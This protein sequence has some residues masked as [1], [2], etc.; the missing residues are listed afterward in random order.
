[1][2]IAHIS[3]IHIRLASRHEEYRK[4]F[5]SLFLS[6]K[7]KAVDVI[8]IA[9]DTLHSKSEMSPESIIL[10]DYFFENLGKIAPTYV[11]LGNHDCSIKN[12]S[13]MDVLSPVFEVKKSYTNVELLTSV[14]RKE[15]G[16]DVDAYFMDILEPENI[17]EI[18]DKNKCNIAIAHGMMKGSKSDS[19]FTF[20]SGELKK[21]DFLD[22]DIVMLGDI[23]RRQDIIPNKIA[24]SGSLIQQN[25]GESED[26]G[27]LIWDTKFKSYEFVRVQNDHVF[28]TVRIKGK[29][30]P[31]MGDIPKHLNLR[32]LWEMDSTDIVDSEF[33]DIHEK[34]RSTYSPESLTVISI[35]PEQKDD[36]FH[37]LNH[38]ANI[39]QFIDQALTQAGAESKLTKDQMS[40]L[41]KLD[42]EIT[43]KTN[44]PSLKPISWT[45]HKQKF[46]NIFSYGKN[47][48][49]DWNNRGVTG[50]FAPNAMGKSALV[51]SFLFSLYGKVSRTNNL[52]DVIQKGKRSCKSEIYLEAERK[53]Y[54]IRRKA[55]LIKARLKITSGPYV[56][57]ST[58]EV[59][60]EVKEGSKWTKLNGKDKKDTDKIIDRYFGSF[61]DFL[62]TSF[63]AQGDIERFIQAPAP[64]RKDILIRF[65]G[66]DF[67][68]DKYAL[69]K[70]RA[71]SMDFDIK[72]LSQYIAG[73][74][75]EDIKSTIGQLKID[76]QKY[77]KKIKTTRLKDIKGV[78]DKLEIIQEKK[79][80]LKIGTMELKHVESE[81]KLLE[82]KTKPLRLASL[83]KT[84]CRTCLLL[85]GAIESKKLLVEKR[86]AREGLE[87]KLLGGIEEEIK[88][89]DEKELIRQKEEYLDISERWRNKLAEINAKR[90]TLADSLLLLEQKKDELKSM[91]EKRKILDVYAKAIH[92]DGIPYQIIL[93]Y[94]PI[95]NIEI[96]NILSGIVDF[97]V[98]ITPDT[99]DRRA[100]QVYIAHKNG[101]ERLIDVASGMEK[102][103]T[104]L[105]LRA[106]MTKISKL[107]KPT[108][109]VIDEGFGSLDKDNLQSM[110]LLF[111][112]L[113]TM[114]TNILIIS[115]VPDLKDIVDSEIQITKNQSESHISN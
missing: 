66:L 85:A 26:K 14:S 25:F 111:Q 6:L 41:V 62:L 88:S 89:Y 63:S 18:Q 104:S 16:S 13:K 23:H 69:A 22:F 80:L 79:N 29:D 21:E 96:N 101:D 33:L 50:I 10:T 109:W 70:A 78:E 108:I 91:E 64:D 82:K 93:K 54:R 49:I 30:L 60:F 44:I 67:M 11:I 71:K 100:L 114:F 1:L 90:G 7:E 34:I 48:S 52:R 51:D 24:Y 20:S 94:L 3:D 55:R 103:I 73:I 87:E 37:P 83:D 76:S 8:V 74:N 53:T 86:K 81:I 45:P 4:V 77:G 15:L 59:D 46:S 95:L 43:Q 19:G 36:N 110:R 56:T 39:H 47:N 113:K 35:P 61:E 115:H 9:G 107:P 27:Y 32:V 5:S 68:E 31:P 72:V 102:M 92:R 57:R 99:T 28:R 38:D 2:K 40:S 42:Q 12:P 106:S 58:G 84:E 112:K 98:F 105:A 75:A 17:P 65:L 97:S